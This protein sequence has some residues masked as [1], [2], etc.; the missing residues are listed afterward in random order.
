MPIMTICGMVAMTVVL[1]LLNMVFRWMSFA[2]V[3][4]PQFKRR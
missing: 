3:F 2:M 4:V 1:T